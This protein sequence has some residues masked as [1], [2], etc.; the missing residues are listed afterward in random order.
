MTI[1][2]TTVG[3]TVDNKTAHNEKSADY[4]EFISFQPKYTT[5]LVEFFYLTWKGIQYICDVKYLRRRRDGYVT[6]QY[7]HYLDSWPGL[8]NYNGEVYPGGRSRML[9]P[10]GNRFI[11]P[12]SEHSKVR[13]HPL[14][15]SGH[16][17]GM[18]WG[19]WR[20][21]SVRTNKWKPPN[22][23]K[24]YRLLAEEQIDH[25]AEHIIMSL[26]LAEL[27]LCVTSVLAELNKGLNDPKLRGDNAIAPITA[28]EGEQLI[29]LRT[30]VNTKIIPT[31]N[32]L[33]KTIRSLA[34]A[35]CPAYA[36]HGFDARKKL[37]S[38]AKDRINHHKRFIDKVHSLADSYNP[39]TDIPPTNADGIISAAITALHAEDTAASDDS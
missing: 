15:S 23:G 10:N 28:D 3:K 32:A 33:V 20:D 17:A 18:T 24:Y 26:H 5:D 39:G 11:I 16:V 2:G 35:V 25:D 22:L 30:S 29:N 34:N 1:P 7:H 12:E 14:P 9:D 36:S 13:V 19:W 21:P 31:V 4:A 6:D 8:P 37:V 27:G 38:D